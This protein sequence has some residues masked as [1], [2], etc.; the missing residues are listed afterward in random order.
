MLREIAS[1]VGL[2]AERRPFTKR[3]ATRAGASV[4]VSDASEGERILV[5]DPKGHLLFS[6]DPETG[7]GAISVPGDLSLSAPHGDIQLSAGGEVRCHA[8]RGINLSSG[9][10]PALSLQRD[11]AKLSAPKLTVAGERADLV[12][13]ETKIYGAVLEAKIKDVKLV[14]ARVE[15]IA[16]DAVSR[17]KRSIRRVEDL[18]EHEAGRIKVAAQGECSV[19]G[20]HMSI[21]A[22]EEVKIDGEQVYLG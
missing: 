12:V 19:K 6:Y 2:I 5:R 7:R 14:L 15:T 20:Q 8:E 10:G 16:V 4:E 17:L 11:E 21:Q 3:L 9:G 1:R 13:G 18:D 22:E